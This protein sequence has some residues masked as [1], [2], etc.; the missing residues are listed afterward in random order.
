M[1]LTRIVAG[2]GGQGVV[3]GVMQ[4]GHTLVAGFEKKVIATSATMQTIDKLA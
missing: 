2:I 3:Q 1:P 4:S